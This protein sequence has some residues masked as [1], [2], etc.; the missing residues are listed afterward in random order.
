MKALQTGP[1]RPA[2]TYAKS[3]DDFPAGT[4]LRAL[5]AGWALRSGG[6]LLMILCAG[7]LASLATWNVDDPS[8]SYAAESPVE[9]LLGRPGAA[10][11]D[12]T[13]QFLGLAAMGLIF[14]L[15]FLGWNLVRLHRPRYPLRQALAWLVGSVL[16]AAALACLPRPAQWPLPTG[17]G[18]AAG[19]LVL[20]AAAL[21]GDPPSAGLYAALSV[22]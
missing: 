21:V 4:D 6:L 15:L 11:A 13:M 5:L 1:A 10:F 8:F 20:G 2:M 14:P 3:A 17:L 22:V 16:L 18:G 9:N 7:L 12:L 19:D